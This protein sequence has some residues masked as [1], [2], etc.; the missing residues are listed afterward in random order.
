MY[1][2]VSISQINAII[3]F[4]GVVDHYRLMVCSHALCLLTLIYATTRAHLLKNVVASFLY[5]AHIIV[6]GYILPCIY[7]AIINSTH[8]GK[9]HDYMHSRYYNNIM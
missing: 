6:Q 9:L 8:S 1:N 4:I 2:Y 3:I 5:N 7:T